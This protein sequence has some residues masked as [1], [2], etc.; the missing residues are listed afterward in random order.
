M[1]R[2]SDLFTGLGGIGKVV[3]QSELK[4]ERE[5]IYYFTSSILLEFITDEFIVRLSLGDFL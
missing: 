2:P 3:T 1:I 4:G 5:D